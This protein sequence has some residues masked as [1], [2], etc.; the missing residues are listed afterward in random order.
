MTES[1][2]KE[3]KRTIFLT[4]RY[5]N[6]ELEPD[7]IVMMADD[8]STLPFPE[9]MEAFLKYRRNPK[10]R[11]FP[12][13]AQILDI[14]HP[15]PDSRE[16]A[17]VLARKIDLAV[18]KHGWNWEQGFYHK[19]GNWWE[20]DKGNIFSSFKEAVISE[21]GEIGWHTICS[22]GGWIA[23]RNSANE[24]EE[25]IFISQCRDQIQAS[26]NL[27]KQGI[28]VSKIALP[29]PERKNLELVRAKQSL[30]L[31]EAREAEQNKYTGPEIQPEEERK[32]IIAEMMSNRKKALE[33]I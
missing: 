14:V 33:G 9:V 20:D 31:I 2:L 22:R 21:L 32:R 15:E 29:Q 30:A 13:P 18:A 5:Y 1:E 19:D 17:T 23:T 7:V 4:A 6:R 8:L 16:F 25:G 3:L 10:N 27:Q 12:L 26:Y 28:D 11:T 24:M